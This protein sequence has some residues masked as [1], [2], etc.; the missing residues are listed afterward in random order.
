MSTDS[1]IF[2]NFRQNFMQDLEASRAFSVEVVVSHLDAD[3]LPYTLN[4]RISLP[5]LT[6]I[7]EIYKANFSIDCSVLCDIQLD[8][9]IVNLS[10]SKLKSRRFWNFKQKYY[11]ID[12]SI[13]VV[14][15]PV[16]DHNSLNLK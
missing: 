11:Q 7:L 4:K 8:F 6:R 3:L 14:L 13:K 12:Y 15:G 5:D 9:S 2:R 1:P 16:R 10:G